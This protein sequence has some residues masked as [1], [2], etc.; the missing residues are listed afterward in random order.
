MKREW[1]AIKMVFWILPHI[2]VSQMLILV[3][4]IPS[5]HN[6]FQVIN[7]DTTT[8]TETGLKLAMRTPK[9]Y[10]GPEYC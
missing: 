9:Q 2:M 6:I 10:Q 4:Q 1:F 7:E 8:I 5:K 3:L